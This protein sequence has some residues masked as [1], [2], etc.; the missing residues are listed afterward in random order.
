MKIVT[1]FLVYTATFIVVEW[2]LK[3]IGFQKQL[4]RLDKKRHR[5]LLFGYILTFLAIGL[6]VEI[7]KLEFNE[8]LGRPNMISLMLG[9]TM[10]CLYF[11]SFQYLFQ[12][13][14]ASDYF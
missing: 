6:F 8:R 10:F 11:E 9:A 12:R 5:Y 14:R 13:K 2:V 3:R 7:V 1:S 4:S